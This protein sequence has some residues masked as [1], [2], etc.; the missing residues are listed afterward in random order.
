[1]STAVPCTFAPL[2]P[3]NASRTLLPSN[4]L[5]LLDEQYPNNLETYPIPD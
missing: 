2:P 3:A 1:M 4:F 5:I